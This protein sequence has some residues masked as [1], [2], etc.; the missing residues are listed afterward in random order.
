MDSQEK[1]TYPVYINYVKQDVVDTQDYEDEFL[2]Q[3]T[4]IAISKS[5]RS[6]KSD[7]VQKFLNCEK[8]GIAVHLFVRKNKDDKETKEFYYLGRIRPTGWAEEFKMPVGADAVKI[9]WKL[10]RPVPNLYE[11]ITKV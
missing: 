1:N 3:G 6:L 9:K 2:D 4:L 8:L 11:Y 10:D 7:D 5:F